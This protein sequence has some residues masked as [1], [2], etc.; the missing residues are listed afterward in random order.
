M[1]SILET[2][3]VLHSFTTSSWEPC[4]HTATSTCTSASCWWNTYLLVDSFKSHYRISLQVFNLLVDELA[5]L[6]EYT[7]SQTHPN[8][9]PVHVQVAVVLWRFAN[10]HFGFRIMRETLGISDSSYNNFTNR[11]NNATVRIG[12]RVI[13]WPKNDL[14]RTRR[15]TQGFHLGGCD[16]TRLP[17]GIG[18][19]DGKL[20]VI[21]KPSKNGDMYVDRKNHASI[22][23]LA[24]CDADTRSRWS[25]QAKLA[26]IWRQYSACWLKS[27]SMLWLLGRAKDARAFTGSKFYRNLMHDPEQMCME[28]SYIVAGKN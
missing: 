8:S 22:S 10:S 27:L 23:L 7:G 21:Q 26:I 12:K 18:A 13:T 15:I 20:V 2:H 28:G 4:I 11:F 9:Y 25:S 16:Q 1:G 3:I 5:Q 24:V 6:P 14:E 19:M 17:G